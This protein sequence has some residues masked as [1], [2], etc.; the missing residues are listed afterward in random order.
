MWGPA[1][2]GSGGQI[3]PSMCGDRGGRAQCGQRG[4]WWAALLIRVALS[5]TPPREQRWGLGAKGGAE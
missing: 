3:E 2:A 1:G 5:F 4:G